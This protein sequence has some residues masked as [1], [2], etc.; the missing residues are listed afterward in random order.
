MAARAYNYHVEMRVLRTLVR[1]KPQAY[2]DLMVAATPDGTVYLN[3][4]IPSEADRLL[5]EQIILDVP[6][7][8]DVF[9]DYGT[10]S[11]PIP[12]RPL[13]PMGD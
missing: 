5:I 9:F 10:D 13:F 12:R 1:I 2:R 3:G 4:V 8:T 7:V 6:G 11:S